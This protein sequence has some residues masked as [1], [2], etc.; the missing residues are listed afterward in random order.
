MMDN[1]GKCTATVMELA[2]S[3]CAP[4][5][6]FERVTVRAGKL[7]A[8]MAE[9]LESWVSVADCCEERRT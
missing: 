7:P 2:N 1:E 9:M 5:A 8:G 6:P 4:G 3:Q